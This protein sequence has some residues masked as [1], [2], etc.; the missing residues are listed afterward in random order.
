MNQK[1]ILAT[2]VVI[3]FV[4]AGSTYY[5][6]TKKSIQEESIDDTKT[7]VDISDWETLTNIKYNYKIKYPQN[8]IANCGAPPAEYYSG[9]C[10]Y[11]L[12]NPGS[13][14]T[15]DIRDPGEYFGGL[16]EKQLGTMNLP[17][18]EYVDEIW[19]INKS[20]KSTD[21]Q[22]SE[23]FEENIAGQKAYR[24]LLTGS[25]MTETGGSLIKD[26]HILIFT[27]HPAGFNVIFILPE[28]PQ[29]YLDILSTFEFLES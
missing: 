24:F 27:A 15:I 1:I 3:L 13:S 19:Q 4:V 23:I 9:V 6:V 20:E 16:T 29:V 14:L 11:D 18:N 12:D 2:L 26:K 7:K 8:F 21:K 5:V 17:L 25:I 10:I 28:N 22:V